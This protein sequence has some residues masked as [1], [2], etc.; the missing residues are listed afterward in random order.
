MNELKLRQVCLIL[1]AFIPVT[2]IFTLPATLSHYAHEDLLLSALIPFALDFLVLGAVWY[3]SRR[4]G[5]DFPAYIRR[6]LGNTG[7]KIYF[8]LYFVYFF[9]KAYL[10]IEEQKDFVELTLY[11]TDPTIFL[12]F[13]FFF[14][15]TYLAVKPL[16][17]LGRAA[18]ILTG[19]TILS[20]GIL[21]FLAVGQT[22]VAALLPVGAQGKNIFTATYY[23][24]SWFGDGV[25]F[26]FLLGTFRTEKKGLLKIM[27]SYAG[28]ALLT[29]LFLA[30]FYGSF[31]SLADR[32]EFALNE[33]SKYSAVILA[34]GRF[35]YIAIFLFLGVG[36]FSIA[37]PLYFSTYALRQVF[38]F[39]QSPLPAIIVNVGML[40]FTLLSKYDYVLIRDTL[41]SWNGVLVIVF[42]YVI[43]I[44]TAF[45]KKDKTLPL[46][47]KTA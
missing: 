18:D 28:V 40:A 3:A 17:T 42:S 24:L 22:D 4:A 36:V 6:T 19:V 41:L 38:P 21:L 20:F 29:L 5:C 39:K 13:P 45:F 32:Q 10:P 33:M 37:L 30:V 31:S 11:E 2:K 34:V 43:P 14:I 23:G 46:K 8:F 35:D 27:L 44:A 16:R 47:E 26:L 15:S 9:L 25:Y 12:F 7:A 1:L